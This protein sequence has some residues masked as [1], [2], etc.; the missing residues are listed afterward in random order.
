MKW[1]PL[2]VVVVTIIVFAIFH[3]E[4]ADENRLQENTVVPPVGAVSMILDREVYHAGETVTL[5]IINKGNETLLV[6]SFYRLYRLEDDGWQEIELGLTFTMIGY[7]IPP[8]GNWTQ[9]IPLAII[10]KG[11]SA[12]GTLEPLPP[13][14]YRI[15]KTVTI[16]SGQGWSRSDEIIL[17]A[18]F[19]VV[20]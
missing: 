17:S 10:V 13:G 18:E 16:D 14:R 1:G 19:E 7:M 6:G 5:T 11:K 12:F 4:T 3:L 15:E 20:G 2:T 9:R 8:G